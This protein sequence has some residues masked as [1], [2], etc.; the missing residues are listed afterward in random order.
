MQADGHKTG[1]VAVGFQTIQG[2]VFAEGCVALD[3]RP[4]LFDHIDL[5][6]QN[7]SGKPVFRDAHPHH[8]AGLGQFF[9]DGD[10]KALL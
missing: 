5:T 8:A 2:D 9:K 6:G 3:R 10:P 7:I 1:R 4:H